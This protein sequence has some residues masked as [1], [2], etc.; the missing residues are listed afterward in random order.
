MNFRIIF[1]SDRPACRTVAAVMTTATF[2]L[3]GATIA[4]AQA[5]APAPTRPAAPRP[6]PAAPAPAQHQVPPQAAPGQQGGQASNVDPQQLPVIYSPWTKICGKDQQQQNAKETCLIM[7]EARLETGQFLAGVAMIEQQGEPKKL[8]RLTMPLGM[9]IQPGTRIVVD[10]DPFIEGRYATCLPNG[11]MADFEVDANF[12]GKLKHGQTLVAQAI[13]LQ[14]GPI[15][16]PL[17][18]ADF[19]KAYD[20]PPTD[21][22]ALEEQQRKLQEELQRKADEARKKLLEKQPQAQAGSK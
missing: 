7:K 2:V 5:P 15:G 1:T 12:V 9:Q 8:L 14:G 17:S 3:A 11:C 6:A 18:L 16:I 10:K 19:A 20:G 21:P 4:A 13:N 22:K